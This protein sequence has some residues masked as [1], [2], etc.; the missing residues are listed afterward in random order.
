MQEAEDVLR[1]PRAA[2]AG[3]RPPSTALRRAAVS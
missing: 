1:E 3:R 2:G